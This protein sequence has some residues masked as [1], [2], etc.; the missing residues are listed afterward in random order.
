MRY[1]WGHSNTIDRRHTHDTKMTSEHDHI[2]MRRW[3]V[4][5]L[6]EKNL[7]RKR[8]ARHFWC[9]LIRPPKPFQRDCRDENSAINQARQG[10]YFPNMVKMD[11]SSDVEPPGSTAPIPAISDVRNCSNE[12]LW[13]KLWP[14]LHLEHMIFSSNV[15]TNSIQA[16]Q[17][18]LELQAHRRQPRRKMTG[19]QKPIGKKS[20]PTRAA[21]ALATSFSG[22]NDRSTQAAHC[23]FTVMA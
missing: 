13:A 21:A 23:T 16:A 3:S 22:S 15:A 11:A 6:N 14:S 4:S 18:P 1:S 2:T 12:Q 20:I 5:Y 10:V 8:S 19:E 17:R 9:M 7:V